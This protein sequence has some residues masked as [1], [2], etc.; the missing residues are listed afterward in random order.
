MQQIWLMCLQSIELL[1]KFRICFLFILLMFFRV[2]TSFSFF[3]D[4]MLVGLNCADFP[5]LRNTIME[6]AFA[7]VQILLLS[8]VVQWLGSVVGLFFSLFLGDLLTMCCSR[9]LWQATS[10]IWQVMSRF[11]W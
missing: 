8:L 9:L 5:H 10:V 3:M 11:R 6:V 1:G 4:K 2:N 7:S